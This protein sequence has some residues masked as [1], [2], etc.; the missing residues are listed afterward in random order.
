LRNGFFQKVRF[1]VLKV[2]ND[3]KPCGRECIDAVCPPATLSVSKGFRLLMEVIVAA[4]DEAPGYT[5]QVKCSEDVSCFAKRDDRH[6]YYEFQ[7]MS[8]KGA[9]NPRV[10]LPVC[11]GEHLQ[12]R[13]DR[14]ASPH[15]LCIAGACTY[16][17]FNIREELKRCYPQLIENLDGDVTG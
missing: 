11:F 15:S 3:V 4:A 16:A 13:G 5:Q 10:L 6:G 9:E 14:S 2:L 1:T 8:E 17:V 12:V 7:F